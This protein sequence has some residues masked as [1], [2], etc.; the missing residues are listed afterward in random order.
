MYPNMIGV[1]SERAE[2]FY[3]KEPGCVIM[4]VEF[5]DHFIDFNKY[6]DCKLVLGFRLG[7]P[8]H[9]GLPQT[10]LTAAI[11]L[12]IEIHLFD[13]GAAS[14]AQSSLPPILRP[15]DDIGIIGDGQFSRVLRSEE[16]RVGKECRS[17]WSPYH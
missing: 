16:R 1:R 14:I 11:L 4:I 12:I 9:Y 7:P 13:D 5:D 15:K 17:R 3:A 8:M 10:E 6:I 2:S